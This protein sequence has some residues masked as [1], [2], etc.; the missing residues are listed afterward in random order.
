VG[1][2][3]REKRRGWMYYPPSTCCLRQE[4]ANSGHSPTL[5][6]VRLEPRSERLVWASRVWPTTTGLGAL[7]R[8]D[9]DVILLRVESTHSRLRQRSMHNEREDCKN[10]DRH[11]RPVR[12]H[13]R[14]QLIHGFDEKCADLALGTNPEIDRVTIMP[15]TGRLGDPMRG[16]TSRGISSFFDIFREIQVE[17]A[18]RNSRVLHTT[19]I[20]AL[21]EVT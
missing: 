21:D 16:R 5:G 3:V 10:K 13:I 12:R 7:G 1:R 6:S 17:F 11:R 8:S 20:Q 18:A 15:T 14:D 2:D 4:C 9:S 19:R